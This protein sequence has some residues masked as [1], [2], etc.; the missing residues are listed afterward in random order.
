MRNDNLWLSYGR[1]IFQRYFTCPLSPYG[2]YTTAAV[3][4]TGSFR[5][6][7]LWHQRAGLR[8][9]IYWAIFIKH[10]VWK[11]PQ[12]AFRR[13]LKINSFCQKFCDLICVITDVRIPLRGFS[14]EHTTCIT[15]QQT[16][17][18]KTNIQC[19]WNT[20]IDS[21]HWAPIPPPPQRLRRLP[22]PPPPHPP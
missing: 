17:Y 14:R 6:F 19:S 3:A 4:A 12:V 21:P 18:V 7:L 16:V 2:T 20:D 5:P 10:P 11:T 13:V 9:A 22:R 1:L 8:S 15:T